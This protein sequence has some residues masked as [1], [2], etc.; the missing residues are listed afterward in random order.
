MT[1]PPMATSCL[2][3][4]TPLRGQE[5]GTSPCCLRSPPTSPVFELPTRMRRR[6][7]WGDGAVRCGGAV[8]RGGAASCA[9][10]VAV[11]RGAAASCVALRRR[12]TAWQWRGGAGSVKN[13]FRIGVD[14]VE[15]VGAEMRVKKSRGAF[16]Q[17]Y[18]ST[19]PPRRHHLATHDWLGLGLNP[20][21]KLCDV[22]VRFTR[23][24]MFLF[25]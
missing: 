24:G 14:K 11:A 10:P 8:R 13:G 4:T 16:L 3:S 22:F 7:V 20:I 12:R 6:G 1:P 2:P 15:G 17:N 19:W 18:R 5:H 23:C 25:V 9:D 21:C